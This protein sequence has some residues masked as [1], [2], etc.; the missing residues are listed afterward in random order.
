M[1]TGDTK[2]GDME[3][4]DTKTGGMETGDT[5]TG[6]MSFVFNYRIKAVDKVAF[7]KYIA[8]GKHGSTFFMYLSGV[9]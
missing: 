1:E 4:G 6:D 5:K 3:T 9:L 8:L 7:G 2:T